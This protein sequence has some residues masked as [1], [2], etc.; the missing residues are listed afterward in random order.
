MEKTAKSSSK[1]R[2]W[3]KK[4][5]QSIISRVLKAPF[6]EASA[7]HS[8]ASVV[9]NTVNIPSVPAYVLED[10]RPLLA[11]NST[12]ARWKIDF[13]RTS[14]RKGRLTITMPSHSHERFIDVMEDI[15]NQ[16]RASFVPQVKR[17]VIWQ[18]RNTEVKTDSNDDMEPDGGLSFYKPD[19]TF[20]VLEVAH[21]QKEKKARRKAQRYVL[22]TNR[23]IKIVVIVI[24]NKRPTPKG[25]STTSVSLSAETD[26]VHVAVCKSIEEPDAITGEYV[27]D[28][29]QIFPGP[30]PEKTFDITWSDVNRGPW[31]RFRDGMR[32]PLDTPEPVCHVNFQDLHR[33]AMALAN[34]PNSPVTTTMWDSDA[35]TPPPKKAGKIFDPSSSPDKIPSSSSSGSSAEGRRVDPSY[36]H[37]ETSSNESD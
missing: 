23:K 14:S 3:T 5:L 26:T 2:Q 20:L 30:V 6:L 34:D 15:E 33:I 36:S 12:T 35:E 25:Q 28:R 32:L 4:D 7:F 10:L 18:T 21:S 24:V 1:G 13:Q 37:S 16:M 27:V 22:E 19:R 9:G 29:L 11:L 31:D 17:K 8:S